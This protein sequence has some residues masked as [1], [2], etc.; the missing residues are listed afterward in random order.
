MDKKKKIKWKNQDDFSGK[1]FKLKIEV[2]N[3]LAKF[4][5]EQWA[6][7]LYRFGKELRAVVAN[8]F[9]LNFHFFDLFSDGE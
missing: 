7:F 3:E 5:Q 8:F 6:E 1:T 4:K 9:F 2:A